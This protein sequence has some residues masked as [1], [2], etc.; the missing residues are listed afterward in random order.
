[1]KHVSDSLYLRYL[2][3]ACAQEWGVRPEELPTEGSLDFWRR[4]L[5]DLDVLSTRTT[6]LD[7][8]FHTVELIEI[9]GL[10]VRN[11]GAAGDITVRGARWVASR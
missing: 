7:A 8:G 11:S 10:A 6:L 3:E 4:V 1:M 2:R 9:D 5:L